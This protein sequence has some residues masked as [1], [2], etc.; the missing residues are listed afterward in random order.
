MTPI[1]I[2][3]NA[4]RLLL[5]ALAA[6]F[7]T[8]TAARASYQTITN[9]AF[10]LTTAGTS[11]PI[12]A[13]GGGIS[14]FGNTYYWYGIQYAG[15][16][17]YY[18]SPTS[19][20]AS[21]NTKFVAVNCYSSTDMVHWTFQGKIIS[22]S[23]P[24][25]TSGVGWVGRMG[26]VVYNSTTNQY[27][28]WFQYTGSDGSG[29]VCC[30]GT[31]PTG[32]FVV[33]NVQTAITNVY[34]NTTGDCTIFCDTDHGST[35]YLVFSDPHGREHLYVSA[36]GSDFLSVQPATL[37]SEWPQGQEAN[38]MFE[39]NGLYYACMS[40]LAGWSYSSA[41]Q[42]NSPNIQTPSSYTADSVF[43]GTDINDTYWS[44]ISFVVPVA[45]NQTTSYVL[46]GDR[47][48]QNS[49]TYLSAGHGL[50]YNIMGPL[51]FNG[52]VPA[53]QP[54]A[55]FQLDAVTG[56][57]RAT[58]AFGSPTGLTA[59]PASAQV[60]LSWDASGGA[61]SYNVERAST[62]SG[63]YSVIATGQTSTVYTDSSLTNGSTY[64]YQVAAV[65]G[66][67]VS[68][69]TLPVSAIPSATPAPGNPGE[70]LATT[71]TSQ[72]LLS[73]NQSSGATNYI[74][75]RATSATGPYSQI[76]SGTS[77]VFTDPNVTYGPTYYYEV[78][79]TTG[80]TTSTASQYA[81]ASLTGNV[82]WSGSAGG[83]W[84]TTT[85][86][87][88]F[89]QTPAL[90]EDGDTV[91]FSDTASAT[92]VTVANAVRPVSVTFSNSQASYNISGASISGT[93]NL[94][95]TGTGL[96]TLSSSNS[97]SGL[98]TIAH[99][100]TLSLAN[101]NALAGSTLNFTN[102]NVTFQNSSETI[103]GLQGTSATQ[104]LVLQTT[105]SA[106]VA[107]T[108]G[109]GE[110]ATTYAGNL[111]GPGSLTKTGTAALTL[112]NATYTGATVVNAGSLT[113]GGS[114]GSAGGAACFA[115]GG[116][117]TLNGGNLSASSFENESQSTVLI[118]GN[119]S[120]S[121][122]GALSV[123]GNNS[124]SDGV[125]IL[126]SGVINAASV[127]VG[128]DG[129]NFGGTVPTA[130]STTDGLYVDGGTLTVA[131]TLGVGTPSGASSSPQMRVDAGTVTVR[132][133]A[134]VTSNAGS[135]F[136]VLDLNGGTFTDND[137][138]GTG[139]LVGGNADATLDA[140]LLVRGTA[141]VNTP[142]ITLG[143]S[144]DSG[145]LLV[146]T[147]IGGTTYIGGGG[148]AELSS[149]VTT[150]TVTLGSS[151]VSTAPIIAAGASWYSAVPMALTN[152]SG[153]TAVTFQTANASNVP[154]NITLAGPLTGTGGLVKTGGGMLILTGQ[155]SF[156]GATT[157]SGGVLEVTG[158]LNGTTS[159]TINSGAVLYMAGGTLSVTG[160]IT[161]NGT[162]KLSGAPTISETGSLIN[163]GVLDLINGSQTLPAN[164][165]NNGTILT[166][167]SVKLQQA[168]VSG[169]AFTVSILGYA[170][171]TYQLERASSL[172]APVTWTSVGVP[173]SG[174]GSPLNFS[175]STAGSQGAFYKIQVSP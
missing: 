6:V 67:T 53:F 43:Q 80:S 107:F 64:Y 56:N 58:P 7:F 115:N 135:R 89:S 127:S 57:W 111:S 158:S 85:N 52:T 81:S 33:N 72:V 21:A 170:Q 17:T 145:G 18:N 133:I 116:N 74:V 114:V 94:A 174:A 146:W 46:V 40:N 153:G 105:G 150:V 79:A 99:G 32:S 136:T 96:V 9:D 90:Y 130:G 1:V 126:Q 165:T 119:G 29:Q 93:G 124:D 78:L 71:S 156:T 143:N 8:P 55:S 109:G 132:G 104:N 11:T 149:T 148:V 62:S 139:I 159:L 14:K 137:S 16:A 138:S 110:A 83:S 97:Y 113:L 76:T 50:G 101:S 63:P 162:L 3:A 134:T 10:Y 22:T 65:N 131:N 123:N 61:T 118:E 112:S 34:F 27:V 103:G 23:T 157:V 5:L 35:P 19:A 172:T 39:R 163:N 77:T 151:T 28:T 117:L 125:V 38:N 31:S 37:I 121:I 24:G 166:S 51:T 122:S 86:N 2:R 25:F 44:Q 73:W 49:S 175:D 152:S 91:V 69:Y 168:A 169:T 106:A 167:S 88:L 92:N 82:V 12:Y 60:S 173:Q 161:N 164:L 128:R 75:E 41:Y 15:M 20:N 87:W 30:T 102:G 48:S 59:T 155:D 141:I 144:S 26:Q 42:V 95:L 54:V 13:Q 120:M 160:G 36:L 70:L 154:E 147:D 171:H 129:A 100:G 66:G 47:W 140:E 84:D 4:L 68:S 142:A 98:T 108:V 45:G